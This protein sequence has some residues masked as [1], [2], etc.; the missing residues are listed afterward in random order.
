MMDTVGLFEI[1]MLSGAVM[2][3]CVTGG[4]TCVCV[5]VGGVLSSKWTGGSLLK[6]VS[7]LQQQC[8]RLLAWSGHAV[9]NI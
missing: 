7:N 9:L 5:C 1:I 2:L 6:T 8:T 4:V 3:M